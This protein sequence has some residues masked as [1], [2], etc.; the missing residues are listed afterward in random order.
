M[1]GRANPAASSSNSSQSHSSS[2]QLSDSECPCA[3]AVHAQYSLAIASGL[4]SHFLLGAAQVFSIAA[5]QLNTSNPSPNDFASSLHHLLEP[6]R[7]TGSSNHRQTNIVPPCPVP[8]ALSRL[9]NSNESA[10]AQKARIA[11]RKLRSAR[12]SANAVESLTVPSSSGVTT[13]PPKPGRDSDSHFLIIDNRSK[14][15]TTPKPP[16]TP[17]RSTC[18][19]RRTRLVSDTS[20]SVSSITIA[21]T[22]SSSDS[23]SDS[24]SDW[25]DS[26]NGKKRAPIATKRVSPRGRASKTKTISTG[27]ARSRGNKS[28]SKARRLDSAGDSDGDASHTAY[29]LRS[30]SSRK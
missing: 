29:P 4:I 15:T 26:F 20:S 30:R 14:K 17:R 11:S 22:T 23:D 10:S 21:S 12:S 28:V 13:R 16:P 7:C 27:A 5:N 9:A 1:S 25:S 18:N 6:C 24:D 3:S 8:V 19:S 2:S